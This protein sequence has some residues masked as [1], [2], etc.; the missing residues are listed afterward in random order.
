[1]R[2]IITIKIPAASKYQGKLTTVFFP[3]AELK[4]RSTGAGLSI[5]A[6]MALFRFARSVYHAVC[7]L[8]PAVRT[9]YA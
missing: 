3:V 7:D 1:M 8:L 6:P 5:M 4:I 9:L 2:P